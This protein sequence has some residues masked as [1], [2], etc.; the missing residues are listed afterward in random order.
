MEKNKLHTALLGWPWSIYWLHSNTY[1]IKP[2]PNT[3]RPLCAVPAPSSSQALSIH[4]DQFLLSYWT[5]ASNS[6]SLLH[7][8]LTDFTTRHE[9]PSASTC[10]VA[11]RLPHA[12]LSSTHQVPGWSSHL[13]AIFVESTATVRPYLSLSLCILCAN[14]KD[15]CM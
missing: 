8:L 4:P 9:H 14:K 6:G 15:C 2:F 12:A 10:V 11:H 1:K 7:S 5:Q 13:S 3:G